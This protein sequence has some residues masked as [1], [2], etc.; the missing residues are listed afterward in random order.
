MSCL[1]L[2]KK[3]EIA[4]AQTE[5]FTS[6]LENLPISVDSSTWRQPF[7]RTMVLARSCGLS[8]YDAACLELA[9]RESLML[10]GLDRTLVGAAE[11]GGQLEVNLAPIKNEIYIIFLNKSN[12]LIA[13]N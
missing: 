10:A 6:Q 7:G 2:K 9:V 11:R 5:A 13:I 3:G 4:I 12:L 1:V 8:S